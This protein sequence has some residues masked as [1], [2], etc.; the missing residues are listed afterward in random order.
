MC[1]SPT[2][3]FTAAAVTGALGLIAVARTQRPQDLPLALTPVVFAVQQFLEG[4]V[5]LDLP[6]A[7]HGANTAALVL[8]YL[9][10]AQVLWPA[11][12]P[13]AVLSLE[14]DPRRRRMIWPC[15]FIGAAVSTWL[16][17]RLVTAGAAATIQDGHIAYDTGHS[18]VAL[19]GAAYLTAVVLAPLLS[20][21][22]TV[23]ALGAIVGVGWIV[24][25]AAY[26]AAFQSIW[27]YVAAVASGMVVWHFEARRR[28]AVRLAGA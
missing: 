17:W 18:H 21:S 11:W 1:F 12:A 8:A 2:A 19:V 6:V 7:P 10:F 16:L 23:V 15:V 25:Y 20:S 4:F 9:V 14:P 22:R 13:F 27:C 5:W 26:L 3:S 28:R 24:A